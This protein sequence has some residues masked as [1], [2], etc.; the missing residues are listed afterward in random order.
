MDKTLKVGDS[1]PNFEARDSQGETIRKDDLLGAPFVIYFYPKDDTPGCTKEACDFRDMMEGFENLDVV[2]VG[3]SPD[4]LQSHQNFIKKYG[5]NFPL[6]TDP[7]FSMAR[8]FGVAKQGSGQ[9]LAVS[10]STFVCDG[11][12]VVQ[13][14]ESPVNVEGHVERVMQALQ[15]VLE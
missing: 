3:V 4:N 11:G 14:V 10:R 1:I 9:P 15:D 12:G 7:E 6:L 5:L 2:V 13:W 8:K